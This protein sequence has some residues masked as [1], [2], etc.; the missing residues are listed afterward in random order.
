MMFLT[1]YLKSDVTKCDLAIGDLIAPFAGSSP[2]SKAELLGVLS[3]VL[4]ALT[5]LAKWRKRWL[6]RKW[7]SLKPK[8]KYS[9]NELPK[10][11]EGKTSILCFHLGYHWLGG[12]ARQHRVVEP[13]SI[14]G[15]V[16]TMIR[17]RRQA[18]HN[19]LRWT[20]RGLSDWWLQTIRRREAPL[21]RMGHWPRWARAEFDRWGGSGPT[22]ADSGSVL[23]APHNSPCRAVLLKPLGFPTY[24]IT[25]LRHLLK[26]WKIRPVIRRPQGS[27]AW[28]RTGP[29][30]A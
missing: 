11:R 20:W 10:E 16:R 9:T 13:G 21:G 7:R 3:L 15:P 28:V 27:I 6:K 25:R 29:R 18:S 5:T 24:C 17:F 23:Q 8:G 1:W 22:S 12:N 4:T 30:I 14:Y 19:T 26:G 2:L